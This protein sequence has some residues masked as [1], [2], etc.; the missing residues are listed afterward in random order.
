M[1]I[2]DESLEIIADY[3]KMPFAEKELFINHIRETQLI[4]FW[5]SF[6]IF[7]EIDKSE[8]EHKYLQNLLDRLNNGDKSAE[9]RIANLVAAEMEQNPKFMEYSMQKMLKFMTGIFAE[10]AV[11]TDTE[12]LKRLVQSLIAT[13]DV[14]KLRDKLKTAASNAANL[15][16]NLQP[17]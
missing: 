12:T 14:L 1:Y 16:N 17:S 11:Y 5:Q 9:A 2:S 3:F 10:F 15:D 7:Y 8:R 4:L 13:P 6:F